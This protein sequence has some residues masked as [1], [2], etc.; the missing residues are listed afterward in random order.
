M[1]WFLEI[2]I[3]NLLRL[4]FAFLGKLPHQLSHS[5]ITGITWIVLHI[6][7]KS[8]TIFYKNVTKIFGMR[9]KEARI[10]LKKVI[11][12]QVQ[13][14]F[15]LAYLMYGSKKFK[16][17]GLKE[18]EENFKKVQST[19]GQLVI[20]GHIGSW[21]L[22]GYY[23]ALASQKPFY[24]LAK[25]TTA[26]KGVDRFLQWTRQKLHMQV[27][28]NNSKVLKPM[29]SALRRGDTVGFV[30][31][32]KPL[33]RKGPLVDFFCV[34]TE[35]V[36]GPATLACQYGHGVLSIYCIRVDF[37]HYKIISKVLFKPEHGEKDLVSVTQ[38]MA[39]DIEQVIRQY[40]EQWCWNYKR[41]RWENEVSSK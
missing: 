32:Q 20:T 10:F 8:N 12:H 35:F 9:K 2:F 17:D 28:W 37:A 34:P 23:S 40:P 30:M 3:F 11:T 38:T 7:K 39:S 18:L 27:L 24:A 29:I 13:I 16:V 15:D 41:W 36:A 33:G 21:D 14:F 4:T 6:S 19:T 1:K 22:V 25:P 5:L 26:W 31:D